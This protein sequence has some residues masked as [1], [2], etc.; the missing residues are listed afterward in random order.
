MSP[1]SWKQASNS[2]FENQV[3][4][5]YEIT[6]RSWLNYLAEEIKIEDIL[7][8]PMDDWF[9]RYS[10]ILKRMVSDPKISAEVW[11]LFIFFFHFPPVEKS[12]GQ[13]IGLKRV[14]QLKLG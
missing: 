10:W 3:L 2:F 14:F 7:S 1:T 5:K 12:N 13:S 6:A 4:G 11:K 8:M 9:S